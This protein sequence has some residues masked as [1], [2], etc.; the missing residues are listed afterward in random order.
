[1]SAKKDP[2]EKIGNVAPFGLRMLPELRARLEDATRKSGRSMNSEIVHRLNETFDG[3]IVLI[4]TDMRR[5]IEAA[6]NLNHRDFPGELSYALNTLYP[7]PEADAGVEVVRILWRGI[8]DGVPDHLRDEVAAQFKR[9]V[10]A[11]LPDGDYLARVLDED[12]PE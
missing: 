11:N 6:A 7:Q 2:D 10:R 3:A 8:V 9:T 12:D 1:M 4:D 5:R